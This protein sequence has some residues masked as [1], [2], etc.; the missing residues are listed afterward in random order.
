[1]LCGLTRFNR[2]IVSN[3]IHVD[4]TRIAGG[5]MAPMQQGNATASRRASSLLTWCSVCRTPT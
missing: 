1:M 2:Q 4:P 5:E 3:R